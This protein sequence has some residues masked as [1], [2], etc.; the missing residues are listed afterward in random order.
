M[1][2]RQV[3]A[4]APINNRAKLP[5][6]K[7]LGRHLAAVD[8]AYFHHDTLE[9]TDSTEKLRVI[10]DMDL[11]HERSQ[12]LRDLI[13]T[14]RPKTLP[15]AAVLINVACVLAAGL[16]DVEEERALTLRSRK[17]ERIMVGV[18]PVVAQAAGLDIAAMD[19]TQALDLAS[20]RYHGEEMVS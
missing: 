9:P 16:S 7:D 2:A 5:S 15:D 1:T 6:I 4:P 19:W 17:L 12:A 8:R 18:L 20:I 13:A 10:T 14:M 3:R 11:L